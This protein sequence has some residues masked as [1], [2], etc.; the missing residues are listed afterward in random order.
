[1]ERV[2]GKQLKTIIALL[3]L[4]LF[5]LSAAKADYALKFDGNNDFV[6]TD[7]WITGVHNVWTMECWFY[8]DG[9][10]TSMSRA[11]LLHR[12]H[13]EDKAIFLLSV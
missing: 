1:M 11:I 2:M 9:T 4:T 6:E 7:K 8:W 12:A 10:L 5:S 13:N 3:F